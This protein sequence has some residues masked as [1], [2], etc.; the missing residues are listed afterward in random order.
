MLISPDTLLLNR[1]LVMCHMGYNRQTV[2]Y[3]AQD[4]RE[5]CS[6][7]LKQRIMSGMSLQEQFERQT[8]ICTQ[9]R[10]NTLPNVSD[11]FIYEGCE[12]FVMEYAI[13]DDLGTLLREQERAFSYEKVLEWGNQLLETLE[14]L[15]AHE[16][17]ILHGHINPNNIKLLPQGALLLLNPDLCTQISVEQMPLTKSGLNSYLSPEQ[18][19]GFEINQRS[20]LYSLTATLH[21]LL[22]STQPVTA[23]ARIYALMNQ[24]ADPLRSVHE[25]HSHVPATV[26]SVFTMAMK[27]NPMERPFSAKAMRKALYWGVQPMTTPKSTKKLV[28]PPV[29]QYAA[30]Q[31]NSGFAKVVNGVMAVLLLLGVVQ[32]NMNSMFTVHADTIEAPTTRIVIP[33]PEANEVE[34]EEVEASEKANPASFQNRTNAVAQ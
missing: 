4:E 7:L 18:I 21:Y 32:I 23:I 30:F 9:L 2:F 27:V 16:P 5:N 33:T 31:F 19:N 20:D 6:V 24:L 13:G 3:E 34:S 1:Y 11:Y 26:A 29:Q 14:H 28:R 10:H 8:Q 15:H 17:P 22:T 25:L 12:I